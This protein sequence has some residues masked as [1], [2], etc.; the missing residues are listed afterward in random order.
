VSII[1]SCCTTGFAAATLWYDWDTSPQRRRQHPKIAGATPDTSRGPFFFVLVMSGALQVMAKSFSSAL[2]IISSPNFFLAYVVG[3]HMF[4]QL[5]LTARGDHMHWGAVMS[6]QTSLLARFGE[7]VV[8]DF[9]SCWLTRAPSQMHS[10]YFLFNQLSTHASVFVSVD[11]YVS[12]GGEDLEEGM[13]WMS[14]V[15]LFAAWVLTYVRSYG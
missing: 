2:L 5:Y 7:K 13:L 12:A 3:D 9:T 6:T 1:I 14:A 4:Y 8:A 10:A 15:S 11:V